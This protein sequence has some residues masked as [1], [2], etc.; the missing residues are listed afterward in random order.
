MIPLKLCSR[1]FGRAHRIDRRR[2][3]PRQ[4]RRRAQLGQ[5]RRDRR[6]RR[7][8][9]RRQ[10]VRDRRGRRGDH[11]LQGQRLHQR[12]A[13]G[14]VLE[15]F[16]AAPISRG[17]RQLGAEHLGQRLFDRQRF[18]P[19][20][21]SDRGLR[22]ERVRREITAERLDL[23]RVDLDQLRIFGERHARERAEPIE[24]RSRRRSFFELRGAQPTRGHQAGAR[25][26]RREARG[27]RQ[28]ALE[29]TANG[30]R[31]LLDRGWC[32][33]RRQVRRGLHFDFDLAIVVEGIGP[34]HGSGKGLSLR[35]HIAPL[36]LRRELQARLL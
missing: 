16:V 14:F 29:S 30:S 26:A 18:A 10:E 5:R 31:D 36:R 6:D 20:E 23:R 11:V 17:H 2:F 22:R 3:D 13:G 25:R 19:R 33:T 15:R 8:D 24:R 12:H 7:R 35:E 9:R 4:R 21:L 32:R 34:R 27:A 1:G 28:R